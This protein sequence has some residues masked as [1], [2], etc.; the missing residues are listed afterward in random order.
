[1]QPLLDDRRSAWPAPLCR[2]YRPAERAGPVAPAPSTFPA[3]TGGVR[4]EQQRVK[5]WHR[6]R[7]FIVVDYPFCCSEYGEHATGPLTRMKNSCWRRS[8]ADNVAKPNR[9]AAIV[10]SSMT[11]PY[12]RR[13]R[14]FRASW[15]PLQI[16]K[17]LQQGRPW[18]ENEAAQLCVPRL[19]CRP[20]AWRNPRHLAESGGDRLPAMIRCRG[21]LPPGAD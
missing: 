17:R 10:A 15:E 20:N 8:R 12:V 19:R 4:H 7:W 1:M 6:P 18:L 3:A 9:G 14:P 16:I 13:R 5:R 21:W 2:V 11:K